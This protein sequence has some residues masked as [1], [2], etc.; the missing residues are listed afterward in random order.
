MLIFDQLIDHKKISLKNCK[1]L[2]L[3]KADRMLDMSFEPQIRKI[4]QNS[5]L[6]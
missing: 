3:D 5:N 1:Y 6:P 2:V 4:V